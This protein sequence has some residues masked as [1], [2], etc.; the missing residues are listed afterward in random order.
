MSTLIIISVMIVIMVGIASIQVLQISRDSNRANESLKFLTIM[1]E[2][3]QMVA[4]ARTLGKAYDMVPATSAC[5]TGTTRID[6]DSGATVISVCIPGTVVTTGCISRT[7]NLAAGEN[8]CLET[9]TGVSTSANSNLD[10]GTVSSATLTFPAAAATE[11]VSSATLNA[12]YHNEESWFPQATTALWP[13]AQNNQ[14]RTPACVVDAQM[15]L[16]CMR[17]TAQG[18][19]CLQFSVCPPHL[20]A[21]CANPYVQQI[22]VY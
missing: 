9:L 20:G 12:N 17:C 6:V 14:I 10:N 4:R 3:G 19:T 22:A 11:S 13:T 5:P 21:G 18:V 16:G 8:Y 15:W 1:E 2:L 7:D